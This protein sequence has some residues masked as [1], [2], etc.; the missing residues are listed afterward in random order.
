MNQNPYATFSV[1]PNQRWTPVEDFSAR[2]ESDPM[3]LNYGILAGG[4][5]TPADIH[6]ATILGR[7]PIPAVGQKDSPSGQTKQSIAIWLFVAICIFLLLN[8]FNKDPK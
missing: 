4:Q 5:L 6:R 8:W 3:D 7:Q 2:W 1:P